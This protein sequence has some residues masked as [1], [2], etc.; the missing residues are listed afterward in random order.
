MYSI[1]ETEKIQKKVILDLFDGI[2]M[3]LQ[4]NVNIN[5]KKIY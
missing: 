2:E 1:I 3:D 5:S 4:E